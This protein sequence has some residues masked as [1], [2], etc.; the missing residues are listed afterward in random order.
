MASPIAA[1]PNFPRPVPGPPHFPATLN[2]GPAAV[3]SRPAVAPTVDTTN[4]TST[5]GA[6]VRPRVRPRRVCA[7]ASSNLI[8]GS[9]FVARPSRR[10]PSTACASAKAVATGEPPRFARKPTTA[11]KATFC[12]DRSILVVSGRRCARRMSGVVV[13]R[14]RELAE[15]NGFLAEAAE[16]SC[17]LLLVGEAGIGKTTIWSAV[18]DEAADRGYAVLAARP[19]EAEADLPFAVLTDVFARL[20]GR[21]LAER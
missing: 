14:E 3:C 13:G 10:P 8:S 17:G 9:P 7:P 11:G 2:V 19:S 1:P 4:A 21:V 6:I 16:R 15:G 5:S 12:C 18:V 20:D